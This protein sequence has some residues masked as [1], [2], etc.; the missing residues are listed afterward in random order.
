MRTFYRF[1]LWL[2][3]RELTIALNTGRNPANIELLR[4]DLSRWQTVLDNHG[5]PT[6]FD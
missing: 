2:T 4:A 5:L 3:D 1:L 6:L